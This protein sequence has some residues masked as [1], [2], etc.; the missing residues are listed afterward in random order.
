MSSGKNLLLFAAGWVAFITILHARLN[1]DSI[2]GLEDY[3]RSVVCSA[4]LSEE[5][6]RIGFL[7]VTCHLTCPVT[8]FINRQTTG[9]GMYEPIRFASWPELKEAYLA[10]HTEATFILAPMAIALR[11]QGVNIKIV[12]LGHRD[13]TAVVVHKDSAIFSMQDLRGKRIAVPNRYSNQRL[14]F[15]RAMKKAGMTSEDIE[16]VE[17]PPPDMPAALYS[18]SVDAICSGEPFMGQTEIDGYGRVL[19]LTKDVW[20]DFISCVLA[21]REDVIAKR[22]AGVQAIVDGIAKSGKWLDKSMENRMYAAQFVSK[23]YYMQDPRLLTYV[24]SRPPDR[25]KYTRLTPLK[26]EFEEI[27]KLGRESGILQGTAHFADYVDP[28][29]AEVA[30]TKVEAW[31]FS[32]PMP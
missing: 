19:W 21:V 32:K 20:P 4:D 23:N 5:K 16:L 24:L 13:G 14:I 1:P 8:D 9:E 2:R 17:M 31:D 26:P 30:T 3:Y 6:F 22:R 18:K 12:Y 28:S 11:E 29:F 25:V 27:E 7:P 15:Y 10:G